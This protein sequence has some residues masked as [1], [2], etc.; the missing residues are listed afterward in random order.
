MEQTSEK[1]ARN[2]DRTASVRTSSCAICCRICVHSPPNRLVSAIH[3]TPRSSPSFPHSRYSKNVRYS[4]LKPSFSTASTIP[5]STRLRTA[6]FPPLH[7]YSS[8]RHRPAITYFALSSP[9]P[10]PS[11]THSNASL[12]SSPRRSSHAPPCSPKNE[13]SSANSGASTVPRCSVAPMMHWIAS[14]QSL[15][16]SSVP[17]LCRN[18]AFTSCS[19]NT[20]LREKAA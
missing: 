19:G 7:T 17:R 14:S 18:S 15:S 1:R 8:T 3:T 9:Y 4:R 11:T 10:A 16:R 20:P 6:Y 12:S 2:S 13:T 5:F